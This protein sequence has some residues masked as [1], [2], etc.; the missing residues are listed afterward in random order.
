MCMFVV[1]KQF[2]SNL[3]INLFTIRRC[4]MGNKTERSVN[5]ILLNCF[6]NPKG[7]RRIHIFDYAKKK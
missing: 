3:K 2:K 1:Q 6:C 4:P 5:P 7:Q